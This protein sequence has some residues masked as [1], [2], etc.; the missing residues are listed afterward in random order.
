[1]SRETQGAR[2]STHPDGVAHPMVS[3]RRSARMGAA[4][5]VLAART[6]RKY[7]RSPELLVMSLGS[8]AI[9]MLLFRY[10][11][12]GAID[13]GRVP[14]VDYLIPGMV[15]TSVLITGAGLIAIGVAEDSE[16]GFFDRMRSLPAPRLA[17]P[18]GRV[19]GDTLIATWGIAATA[20]LGFLVGFELHGTLVQALLAFGLC[21]I[22]GFAF[23]WMFVCIGLVAGSAQA[24]Q[25][26]S[27]LTWPIL[28]V[29][30]A[31]VQ[32]DTL[33]RWMQPLAEHQP[34]SV[35]CNAVRSLALGDPALAG[36]GHTTAY[37]AVLSL[38]W[39]TGI[40]LVFAPIA[41]ALYRRGS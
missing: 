5:A 18:A 11:F 27:M 40:V 17:L 36:L 30:S 25:G 21:V 2:G 6:V 20:A 19:L 14:Y 7:I 13:F 22:C 15:M 41:V 32:T 37:W 38:L 8:G 23:V 39:A 4:V 9:F 28:F 3:S 16:Q 1:M 10:I 33:P 34:I 12:G 24:A 26:I 31:Y 29:S 35:M